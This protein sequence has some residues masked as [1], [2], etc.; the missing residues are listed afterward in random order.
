[1][2]LS[3]ANIGH[4][5]P[6][7]GTT[8]LV[9][10]AVQLQECCM[11][12]NAQLRV[13]N[14]HVLNTLSKVRA[15]LPVQPGYIQAASSTFAGVSSFG[16]SGAIAHTQLQI[17]SMRACT[18]PIPLFKYHRLVYPW[19]LPSGAT[20]DAL[21]TTLALYS[22]CW[23]PAAMPSR[24]PALLT[25][26]FLHRGA[27]PSAIPAH[28]K[29]LKATF[30]VVILTEL[31]EACAPS[32]TS[33]QLLLNAVQQLFE[34]Q[35][36]PPRIV[37]GT[38]GSHCN[39]PM[40]GDIVSSEQ[41]GSWGFAR[42]VRIEKPSWRVVC[43][44]QPIRPR[45]SVDKLVAAAH[46][47]KV[48]VAFT[49]GSM[50]VLHLLRG[51]RL[52]HVQ[53]REAKQPTLLGSSML[54]TGGL[55]GLGLRA[56]ALLSGREAS[57]VILSS[58]SGRV[59][60]DKQALDTKLR[61]LKLASD[62]RIRKVD[63][64]DV[65]E[66]SLLCRDLCGS[67]FPLAGFLHA[68][69]AFGGKLLSSLPTKHLVEQFASKTS[70][71]WLLHA[72]VQCVAIQTAFLFSS[73]AALATASMYSGMAGYAAS[74]SSL[75]TLSQSRRAVGRPSSALQ[76]ANVSDMGHG[77]MLSEARARMPG[78]VRIS[79]ADYDAAIGTSVL[80][81]PGM[82]PSV[83]SV[84]PAMNVQREFEGHARSMVTDDDEG[85]TSIA[86]R[87]LSLQERMS[88]SFRAVSEIDELT[89]QRKDVPATV[90]MVVVGCGLAG[91]S[92][93]ITTVSSGAMSAFVIFEKNHLIGGVWRTEGNPLSRVNSSMPGYRL[94]Y[95]SRPQGLTNHSY[96]FEMLDDIRLAINQFQL[97]ARI[98]L[99]TVVSNIA[100]GRRSGNM[101][102]WCLAGTS[103]S[104]TFKT[105]AQAVVLC[106]SRR[107]GRRRHLV[108]PGEK[109]YTGQVRRG[110]GGDSVD[111]EWARKSVLVIGMG[112]F[113]IEMARTAIENAARH[114]TILCRRHGL[115][116]PQMVEYGNYIR[117]FDSQ[118]QHPKDGSGV[119]LGLWK[120]AYR[121][122][123]A[124][125]PE[126][127]ARGIFRPDG[128]TVSVS[129]IYFIAHF[130]QRMCT[131]TGAIECFFDGGVHS[132]IGRVCLAEIVVKSIGFEVNEGNERFL[133]RAQMMPMCG[134]GVGWGEVDPGLHCMLEPHLDSGSNGLPFA[135]YLNGINYSSKL[136]L[137]HLQSPYS[138]AT[139][140]RVRI[141]HVKDS[142]G[143]RASESMRAQ[144]SRIA[145]SLLA[146]LEGVQWDFKEEWSP[147]EYL[148]HNISQW[149]MLHA[150]LEASAPADSVAE[151]PYLF[152]PLIAVLE[153]EAPQLL[154]EAGKQARAQSALLEAAT[155][156]RHVCSLSKE[157]IFP[158]VM[159][160]VVEFGSGKAVD[161]DTPAMDA[162]I[163]SLAATGLLASLSEQTSLLLSATLLFEHPTP[164]ALALHIKHL[165]CGAPSGAVSG[166][167]L[168]VPSTSV[169]AALVVAG[170][171]GRWPSGGEAVNLFL[172][173][174]D[175]VGEVPVKRYVMEDLVNMEQ[176]T[177]LQRSCARHGSFVAG[178]QLFDATFFKLSNA[179]VAEMDPQQRM[180]LDSTYTAFHASGAR[181][182]LLI[183]S[184]GG[185]LV[186]IEKP[187][188]YSVKAMHPALQYS[189]YSMGDPLSIASGRIGFALG[190]HGPTA[191]IDTACA[192][193][194]VATHLATSVVRTNECSQA[195]GAGV[196]LKLVP[197]NTLVVAAA[198]TLSPD[199]RCKTFD[200]LANGYARAEAVG[201]Q[202][203]R[204]L[205]SSDSRGAAQTKL[206]A[207][208]V[209]RC[210][211][212]SATLTAPNGSA[213][214][215]ALRE[216]LEV[217]RVDVSELNCAQAH[218]TGTGLGDPIEAASLASELC[219]S[220]THPLSVGT[221]K[222]NIGHSEAP[223]G[224][225]GNLQARLALVQ[226]ASFGNAQLRVVNQ[227][228]TAMLSNKQVPFLLPTSSL[229][230]AAPSKCGVS[231]M[232]HSGTIAHS[233][234]VTPLEVTTLAAAQPAILTY[235][236]KAFLWATNQGVALTKTASYETHWVS[237][238][239]RWR[240]ESQS[241][242]AM[243]LISSAHRRRAALHDSASPRGKWDPQR[244]W[245]LVAALFDRCSLATPLLF[246][247]EVTLALAQLCASDIAAFVLITSGTVYKAT[248]AAYGGIWGAARVLALEY[249]ALRLLTEDVTEAQATPASF[250]ERRTKFDEIGTETEVVWLDV[251]RRF[252]SQLRQGI[253]RQAR[254]A[255]LRA[256][257]A[258]TGGLGGLGM[259]ATALLIG[260]GATR[261]LLASRS[262]R[263]LQ[264]A[265][266]LSIR[267]ASIRQAAAIKA[268]AVDASDLSDAQSLLSAGLPLDGM[269]LAAGIGDKGLSSG[270]SAGSLGW[271]FAS[272]ASAAQC[273]HHML[274]G[275][276]IRSLIFYSSVA[277][278]LG[279][280]G[281]MSY[282][283]SNSCVDALALARRG[284]GTTACAIQWPLISG[285]GMGQRAFGNALARG[286]SLPGMANIS[287]EEYASCLK[288]QLHMGESAPAVTL[289]HKSEVRELLSD[290]EN[291]SQ[292]R[293]S[294][295][296]ALAP[297]AKVPMSKQVDCT[298][299]AELLPLT[300]EQ[301]V[302]A[303]EV[304]IL[305]TVEASVGHAE[306]S[307][308]DDAGDG[309]RA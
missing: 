237:S 34:H 238:P 132:T 159:S 118:F 177:H 99:R 53:R 142:S 258:I 145:A 208:S 36:T 305:R 93:A 218:G 171:T 21:E 84:L 280:S 65:V 3:Q 214:R 62:V 4:A 16:F 127:W 309:S 296:V 11:T 134:G 46:G 257:F 95:L 103:S 89:P 163:D 117:P 247:I 181:L 136:M 140:P 115:I 43:V 151:M 149:R 186:G 297:E 66:T 60:R 184:D 48:E 32:V 154:K 2:L 52:V 116:S 26:F 248:S 278:A 173:S 199:G 35:Q 300:Y 170:S 241:E 12:P 59:A 54:I 213:Q 227:V 226:L 204:K 29:Q 20:V 191:S 50:Y 94:P 288:V 147:E 189:A 72:G 254:H 124:T 269:L 215:I 277:S 90:E 259:R 286:V 101:D 188:W 172:A 221:H 207:G 158:L 232:G 55:G 243:L 196:S 165:V 33:C 271:L 201:V 107:L 91:V 10:L 195:I 242:T 75:D 169:A 293:F 220:R 245:D 126:S 198:G 73:L 282:A 58:R 17:H 176:T 308:R 51:Q 19:Q 194:L 256:A 264:D 18:A 141:N 239:V 153:H 304:T 38:A 168:A 216:S 37:V 255:S 7:A 80:C 235:K 123:G 155:A 131:T 135:S 231:S 108:F 42:V 8:G 252:S 193:G 160:S 262:G 272:K 265:S 182:S 14:P 267:Q 234:V 77:A 270:L 164:R 111:L 39:L 162:G 250:M 70:A 28:S 146:H 57:R 13:I 251:S 130:A 175:S 273:A 106:T 292:S 40:A 197:F 133:G 98:V 102:Q 47:D 56:A 223:S 74:N 225:M 22:M 268:V 187:D 71:A 100:P 283:A 202:L 83:Q 96:H 92:V 299:A 31:A 290:L 307:R 148:K 263:L 129:D 49:A 200:R 139:V 87:S 68:A 274:A 137:E 25:I 5:E 30:S 120:E 306:G 143:I 212:R 285:A 203:F 230:T 289:I 167:A 97:A 260:N 233:I 222:A 82:C 104:C 105:S 205:K 9:K 1:M 150:D 303:V 152:E 224:I 211:G 294:E 125:E 161:A 287:L 298:A 217:S 138:L 78:I 86:F 261:V 24:T 61:N 266:A 284:H 166:S 67:T 63:I 210:D 114:V 41:G 144:D 246:G 279:D 276:R 174:G 81:A 192:S 113:A 156:Q 27:L 209:V 6:A 295:L 119:M 110:L 240:E 45:R 44:D 85:T 228:V 64:A 180:I 178:I 76:M 23:K 157:R 109:T 185:A 122:S 244:K 128:H 206:H 112:A 301:R 249:G 79:L 236:Q 302:S 179:E 190:M 88:E 291:A 275:M 229:R 121:I 253:N 183:G 69:S 281:Q 219:A 15:A